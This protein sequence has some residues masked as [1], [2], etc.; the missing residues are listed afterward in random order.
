MMSLM[1]LVTGLGIGYVVG[2]SWALVWWLWCLGM[3]N[4]FSLL[5]AQGHEDKTSWLASMGWPLVAFFSMALV[6]VGKGIRV[7]RGK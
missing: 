7:F 2:F 3:P 5:R 1:V 6:V 4:C